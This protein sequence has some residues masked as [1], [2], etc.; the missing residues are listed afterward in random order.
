MISSLLLRISILLALVGM[1]FGITMGIQQNFMLAPSHAHLNLVGFVMLFL[2]GLY[3]RLVP[4]PEK[5][6]LA[7][8]HAALAVTGA[9]IFPIGIGLVLA[10]GPGFEPFVIGGSLI[11]LAATLCFAV[12][13]FRTS[14]VRSVVVDQ[15]TGDGLLAETAR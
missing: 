10:S 4:E 1:V 12:V 8:V 5:T 7:K 6:I 15:R 3:Y 13:V 11:V 2:A 14:G 9:I